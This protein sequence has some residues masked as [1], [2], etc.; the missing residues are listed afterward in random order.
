V[1]A[2][3]DGVLDLVTTARRQVRTSCKL[4]LFEEYSHGSA[5]TAV[6]VVVMGTLSLVEGL[7]SAGLALVGLQT[8]SDTVA[9][10]SKS[11]LDL[12]LGGLGGVRS[13]LLLGLCTSV[14]MN[15][16]NGCNV[17]RCISHTGREIL[18]TGVRHFEDGL[19]R[20]K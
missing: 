18:A 13:E 7:L 19:I 4:S 12:L 11:L 9:G 2:E 8:T 3:A 15:C 6:G 5:G 16:N 20:R 10:V 17:W 1:V 14:L